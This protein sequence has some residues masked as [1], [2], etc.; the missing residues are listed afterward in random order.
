MSGY[1]AWY[2]NDDTNVYFCFDYDAIGSLEDE[3]NIDPELLPINFTL[4]FLRPH[5]FALEAGPE[6]E[7]F[8]QHFNLT[9][10]DPQLEGMGDGDFTPSGFMAGWNHGNEFALKSLLESNENSKPILK[11]SSED[12]DRAWRWNYHRAALQEEVGPQIQVPRIIFVKTADGVQTSILWLDALQILLP[13][14]QTILAFRDRLAQ[15]SYLVPQVQSGTSQLRRG[16]K[17]FRGV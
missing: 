11:I 13:R 16:F 5:V 1:Q 4:N 3:E 12:I 14:V 6:L 15:R 17:S 9:V 8:I 7:A 10:S 2:R